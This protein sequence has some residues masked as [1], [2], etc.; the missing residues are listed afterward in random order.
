MRPSV[1][2][3]AYLP[4]SLS[5]CLPVCLLS[6]LI[7]LAVCCLH[8]NWRKSHYVMPTELLKPLIMHP[9]TMQFA[10]AGS[11]LMSSAF[12]PRAV[13]QDE[14]PRQANPRTLL[15]EAQLEPR[16]LQVG[17]KLSSCFPC[18]PFHNVFCL[19][20]GSLRHPMPASKYQAK[21]T[22]VDTCMVHSVLQSH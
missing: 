5:V 15:L 9:H 19:P 2:L 3:P 11:G 7:D 16:F 22:A 18:C 10:G 4:A 8:D 14:L 21:Q 17:D 12:A 13:V 20:W 6:Y 1:C